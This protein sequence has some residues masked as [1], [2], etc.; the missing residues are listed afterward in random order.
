MEQWSSGGCPRPCGRNEG[1][2]GC[3]ESSAAPRLGLLFTLGKQIHVEHGALVLLRVHGE[4]W[5]GVGGYGAVPTAWLRGHRAAQ[6]HTSFVHG[7]A[8][9]CSQL[10]SA[11][12]LLAQS[13]P[14]IELELG[15]SSFFLS[16]LHP[17]NANSL[18]SD[19]GLGHVL[20]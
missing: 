8:A 17:P 20:F 1:K 13:N 16:S 5:G 7:A 19:Q 18:S 4:S 2:W 12:G 9:R 15:T 10:L 11:T 14:E 3:R 6:T